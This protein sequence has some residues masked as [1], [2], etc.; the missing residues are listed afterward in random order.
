MTSTC[1]AVLD[2]NIWIA[3]IYWRGRLYQIRNYAEQE[4]FTSVSS[5]AILTEVIRVLRTHFR[6]SDEEVYEWY[7]RIGE[8][9]EFVFPVHSLHVVLD[10]PSD[11]KFVECAIAGL[12]AYIVSRDNDL[13]RL[14]RYDQVKIVDDV[15]FLESLSPVT[16][17]R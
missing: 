11:N 17:Q 7:C 8:I 2:T 9:S 14:G 3:S 5:L 6:L 15:E 1:R 13:L 4:I 16:S 12:A 10:D